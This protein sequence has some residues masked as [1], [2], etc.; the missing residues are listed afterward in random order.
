MLTQE[1]ISEEVQARLELVIE[2]MVAKS[3]ERISKPDSAELAA[4]IENST[5]LRTAISEYF[6]RNAATTVGNRLRCGVYN[7]RDVDKAFNAVWDEQ[8][9]KALEDRIR[10]KVDKAIDAVIAERLKKLL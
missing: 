7:A 8:F 4:M 3:L 1:E 2:S 6:E 5:T 10:G 9:Q